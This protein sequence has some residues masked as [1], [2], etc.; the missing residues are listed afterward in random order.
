MKQTISCDIA[1]LGGGAGG[2]SV[3]AVASQ[4]GMKV[5]LAE[6]G[7]MGGDCLNAGCVPSKSL[8][9]AAKAAHAFTRADRFGIQNVTPTVDFAA[10]MAHVAEVIAR[11]A[12]HDSVERFTRLGVTVLPGHAAFIDKSTMKVGETEVKAR[13]FV[14]ATGSSPAVP[15]VPGLADVPFLTNETIFSLKEKPDHLVIIGAGPI[16]CEMAQA[17]SFLGVKVT[18]LEAFTMMPRDEADLVDM[19]RHEFIQSGIQL[20]ERIKIISVSRQGEKIEIVIE[21]NGQQQVISGS[22]LLVAAG[23]KVNVDGLAL[24]KAGVNYTSKGIQVDNRLRTANK[25]IYAIGDVAGGYQFTHIAGYHA[26]IAIRNM[27]FKWPARV[28]YR[29]IPWVTYTFPPLA[30]AG[31]TTGEAEKQYKKVKIITVNYADNDRAIAEGETTGCLKAI[32]TEK[33]NILGVSILGVNA[34]ELIAPWILLIKDGKTLREMSDAVFPYPTLSE[35]SKRA[36]SEFYSPLLFSDKVKRL[37]R[38]IKWI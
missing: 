10:V 24:E 16:G 23:R 34:D 6:A 15:P 8:L 7:K 9:A 14:V 30:H 38:W 28:D 2:L 18:L 21:Q 4:L 36:A 1:I 26:G 3:A 12:P 19:L 25:K 32:C 17:F 27:I 33:G 13:Y 22:H 11:I 5:V 20:Y 35:I 37:V 31:L 29:A